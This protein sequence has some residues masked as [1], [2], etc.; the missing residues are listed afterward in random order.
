MAKAAKATLGDVM[1]NRGGSL[2]LPW[3][4]TAV[5]I[6]KVARELRAAGWRTK[7]QQTAHETYVWTDCPM[8]TRRD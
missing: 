5:N 4:N 1:N 8:A 6:R 2:I 3:P 7:I